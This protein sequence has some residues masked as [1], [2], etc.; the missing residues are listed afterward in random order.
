[1][2]KEIQK[3]IPIADFLSKVIGDNTEVLI[4]DFTNFQKSIVHIINGN[5]SNRAIGDSI[6]DLALEFLKKESK[7]NTQYLFNYNSKTNNNKVLYSSTFFIRDENN[8]VI[9][10]LCL[11]SD[12]TEIEKSFSLI[13]SFLPNFNRQIVTNNHA[14]VK[15]NLSSDSQQITLNKIDSVIDEFG[16]SP[17]R[18]TIDEK[19]KIISE[20]Q[21]FGVFMLRGSV[22]EVSQKL[23]MSEPSVYRYIK[24]IKSGSTV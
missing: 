17:S 4:H 14:E 22:Q 18:M 24:K 21:E 2:N 1:L 19:T 13:S 8:E 5:I 9:G 16:I 12:Y 3:Y 11:N 20:L 15:E 23:S 6:T 10:A 7:G